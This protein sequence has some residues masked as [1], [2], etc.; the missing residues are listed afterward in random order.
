MRI[1]ILGGSFDPIHIGHLLLAER[2]REEANLDKVWLVPASLSP[3]KLDQEPTDAKQRIEMLRLA[4]AGNDRFEVCDIEIERGGISYTVDT[5]RAIRE[6]QV[7]DELYF[8]MG[9]DSLVDFPTWR[10]PA[11]ICELAKLLIVSRPGSKMDFDVLDGIM[12]VESLVN[13]RKRV[14]ENLLI[15]ISSSDIRQRVAVGKSIRYQTTRAVEEYIHV[16]GL[17]RNNKPP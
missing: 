13:A 7:D 1:G 15:E 3:H 10:K 12:P 4:I 16:N 6:K 5:L 11:K 8:I 17:Y 2:C 14:I 9:A